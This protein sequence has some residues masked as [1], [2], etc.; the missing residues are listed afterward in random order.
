M[1]HLLLIPGLLNDAELWRHQLLDLAPA[2]NC[3]VA[4]I[5]RGETLRE[6]AEQVLSAAPH[7]FAL[8][9]FSLGGFVAQEILRIAPE[10]VARL[11]LLDTS[12]HADTAE[13]AAARQALTA[14]A[15]VTGSDR[16]LATYVA[17][18]HLEDEAIVGCIRDMAARLGAEVFARQNKLERPDGTSLLRSL[19]CPV[20]V[21]CGEKDV[22]TPVEGHLPQT[23]LVI[24]PGNGHMTPLEAPDWSPKHFVPGLSWTAT[25]LLRRLHNEA[26]F[27]FCAESA[28]TVEI[29]EWEQP[30]YDDTECLR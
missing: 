2:I 20:L 5:T 3:E 11:A 30:R 24:I 7:R 28:G 23:K 8:A 27:G 12:I 16:L 18:E 29:F 6:L 26:E 14:A 21:I 19:T 15:S 13:R 10:R 22:I 17:R 4:D 1:P 9:G 25:I